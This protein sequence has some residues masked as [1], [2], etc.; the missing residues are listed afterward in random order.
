MPSAQAKPNVPDSQF[1]P[2]S[3]VPKRRSDAAPLSLYDRLRNLF[4]R[5]LTGHLQPSSKV[6]SPSTIR[7]VLSE[8][9]EN[10]LL[11][12]GFTKLFRIFAGLR[13]HVYGWFLLSFGFYSLAVY[14]LKRFGTDL[15]VSTGH[16]LFSVSL[17]L[18]SIP[19]LISRLTLAEALMQKAQTQVLLIEQLGI[20]EAVI[21]TGKRNGRSNFA[22]LIGMIAGA[23]TYFIPPHLIV[24]AMI[25]PVFLIAVFLLPECGLLGTAILF[26]LGNQLLT[27]FAIIL[28]GI[29]FIWKCIR[30]KR[31]F[32]LNLQDP[33]VLLFFLCAL[34]GG[35]LTAGRT[36]SFKEYLMIIGFV[37]IY[38]LISNL[39]TRLSYLIA[40]LKTLYLTVSVLSFY[41]ALSE[42]FRMLSLRF[43]TNPY[44]CALTESGFSQWVRPELLTV[45]LIFCIPLSI[46]FLRLAESRNRFRYLLNTLFLL[47]AFFLISNARA[48]IALLAVL[49]TALFLT[50]WRKALLALLSV[51]ILLL[52]FQA[53]FPDLAQAT[54]AFV[55]ELI[56]GDTAPDIAA[57]FPL[58]AFPY[59]LWFGGIGIGQNASMQF[60]S[61]ANSAETA[62]FIGPSQLWEQVFFGLGIAGVALL[63]IMIL[64]AFLALSDSLRKA[65]RVS[66]NHSCLPEALISAFV[67]LSVFAF[68]TPVFSLPELCLFFFFLC[69]TGESLR[70]ILAGRPIDSSNG[71]PE[72]ATA[73]LNLQ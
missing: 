72:S 30:G 50:D 39:A 66:P 62:L 6:S 34:L 56:R 8:Q 45:L 19:C 60:G 17:I 40:L 14:L 42:I 13:M 43:P 3:A 52:V 63:L 36:F 31:S 11:L 20:R 2:R 35:I 69:G 25:L 61:F 23:A 22:F 55:K 67:G 38:Y 29:S 4:R 48:W 16:L 65:R 54:F 28:T 1:R 58:T 59:T 47:F 64:L 53:A 70:R 57:S 33:F 27:A 5:S 12:R 46:A 21:L 9:T 49:L 37:G 68:L 41:T 71:T 15:T 44:F 51:A 24:S 7:T 10:S 32:Y 18:L 73:E 26:P